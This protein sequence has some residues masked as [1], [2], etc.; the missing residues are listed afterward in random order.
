MADQPPRIA[1][2]GAGIT[3]VAL[4]VALSRR[5]LECNVFEKARLDGLP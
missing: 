2:V 5:G 4:A 1:I 3:G